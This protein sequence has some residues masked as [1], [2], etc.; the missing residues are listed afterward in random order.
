MITRLVFKLIKTRRGSRIGVLKRRE[1]EHKF[2][3]WQ[4]EKEGSP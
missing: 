1:K 2:P 4:I 3:A